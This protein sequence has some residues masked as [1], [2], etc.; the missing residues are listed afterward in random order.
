[1]RLAER[2]GLQPGGN[3]PEALAVRERCNR[4]EADGLS[5]L[6]R[7][8]QR[9]GSANR[10]AGACAALPP[11]RDLSRRLAPDRRRRDGGSQLP[12]NVAGATGVNGCTPVALIAKAN[13]APH[14]TAACS[15]P[16]NETIPPGA[17]PAAEIGPQ[18]IS[19][20]GPTTHGTV[21]SIAVAPPRNT[22][23]GGPVSENQLHEVVPVF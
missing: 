8:P 14:P 23:P 12:A 15:V 17:R 21:C 13:D 11:I 1:M 16:T 18:T 20:G 5:R 9:R 2:L 7:E 22:V 6:H 4:D 10:A 19:S 3:R